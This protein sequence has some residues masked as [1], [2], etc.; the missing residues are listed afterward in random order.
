[1]AFSLGPV[2]AS[3]SES[4]LDDKT[5]PKSVEEI[6][7]GL[8]ELFTKPIVEREFF[9]RVQHWLDEYAPIL[10]DVTLAV[11]P[12]TYY[13]N[14][15]SE[16]RE[17]REALA[18]GLAL[19]LGTS[20]HDGAVALGGTLYTSQRLYG[21]T[22]R[23]GTG[24]LKPVQEGFTVVGQAW[25]RL[26]VADHS[27]SAYRQTLDLPYLNKN[28][29]RMVPNTFEAYILRGR[30]EALP[31]IESIEYGGGYVT[32]MKAR[33]DDR[34]RHMSDVA[35]VSGS[36]HGLA[37]AGLLIHVLPGL[38]VGA[39][40]HYVKDT[41]NI[42]YVE[43]SYARTFECGLGTRLESQFTH[44]RSVGDDRLTGE[45]FDT[46]VSSTQLALSYRNAGFEVTAST[47]D[48]EEAIRSPFGGYPGHL[49]RIQLDFDRAGEDAW[50]IGVSYDFEE[51]GAPGLSFFTNYNEGYGARDPGTGRSLPDQREFDLTVDYRVQRGALRGLWIRVRGSIVDVEGAS[52]NREQVRVI[53]N[54]DLPIL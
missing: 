30:S 36:E 5:A 27:L 45:S 1:M 33:D 53:L 13:F 37:F 54:Y 32:Q 26:T 48:R 51:L 10:G 50:G 40:D 52:R 34:F 23:G 42:A 18:T 17:R 43:A 19:D 11:R 15:R 6:E 21:K 8:E 28:D 39:I 12:R 47:T 29:W 20:W 25:A 49:S 4:S 38:Q 2:A 35:G 22:R 3:A 16:D 44:Q 9:P 24:L 31:G 14:S 41:I 7:G 46:W